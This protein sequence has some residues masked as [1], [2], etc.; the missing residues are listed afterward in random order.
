MNTIKRIAWIFVVILILVSAAGR[1]ARAA[2]TAEVPQTIQTEAGSLLVESES[3]GSFRYEEGERKLYIYGGTVS[4]RLN[5]AVDYS[6]DRIEVS[7][8]ATLVLSGVRILAENGPALRVIPGAAVE[9]CLAEGEKTEEGNA[10]V[11]ENFLQG[12]EGYAGIEAETLPG[13]EEGRF[14]EA[15][16]RIRGKGYLA[17]VGGEGAAAIGA[18]RGQYACGYIVIEE[19]N[20]T[21]IAGKGADAVGCGA[22]NDAVSVTAP[23]IS[24]RTESFIAFADGTGHVIASAPQTEA[25]AKEEEILPE[26]FTPAAIFKA[27]ITDAEESSV[28]LENIRVRETKGNNEIVFSMPDGY[29]EFAVKTDADSE[30]MIEQ[31]GRIFAAAGSEGSG[32]IDEDAV[33]FRGT[34]NYGDETVFLAPLEKNPSIDIDVTGYWEDEEDADGT[35]PGSVDITLYA[36]GKETGRTI[37]LSEEN[38]WSGTFDELAVYSDGVKQSYSVVEERLEGYTGL[39]SGSDLDGYSIT[40]THE[41]LPEGRSGEEEIEQRSS[42]TFEEGRIVATVLTTKVSRSMPA[43]TSTTIKK[44]HSAKTADSSDSIFWGGILLMAVLALFVWMR[45]EQSRE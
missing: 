14:L 16:L 32:E 42:R 6:R 37:T 41:P 34:T 4:I 13:G 19:G 11:M 8:Y 15:S 45:I 10:Q 44:T 1:S 38:D 27:V 22:G 40:N 7:G 20:I 31:G 17:A 23:L 30:Y 2:E 26:G 18:S 33:L 25:D 28:N 3:A 5:P 43:R 12:A 39:I 24:D 9:I 29:R 36:N 21:A 35:R